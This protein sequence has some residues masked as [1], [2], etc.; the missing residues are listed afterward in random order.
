MNS[1]LYRMQGQQHLS[2]QQTT[3]MARIDWMRCSVAAGRFT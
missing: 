1:V 3:G 2:P